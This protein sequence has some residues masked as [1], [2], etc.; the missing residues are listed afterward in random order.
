MTEID[1]L[2]TEVRAAQASA[3]RSSPVVRNNEP[4]VLFC[5]ILY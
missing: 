2:K 1:A 5:C 3:G 4:E